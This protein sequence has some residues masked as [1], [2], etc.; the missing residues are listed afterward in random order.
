ML[1]NSFFLIIIILF[2]L[3]G[4][5]MTNPAEAN[6]VIKGTFIEA[7]YKEVQIDDK[8]TEKRLKSITIKNDQGKTMTFD[9]DE[10]PKL[11]VDTIPTIIDAFKYGMKIEV[12]VNGKKAIALRGQSGENPG[13]IE[14][15]E[16]VVTGTLNHIDPNG[17]YLSIRLENGQSQTYYINEETE[18]FK[19]TTLVDLSVLYE[20]DRVKF[21][22]NEYDSNYISTVEVN[23]Q[24]IRV[25]H[26][27][28]GTI[29]QIDSVQNKLI[30]KNEKVFQDWKWKA[31]TS[32]VHNS[33]T[34][35]T[36]TPIYVGDQPIKR[37][38]LRNYKNNEVYFV[39]I[40]KLGKEVIDKI[41]I[42]K[43]NERTFYEPMTLV[44]PSDKLLGL[45]NSGQ[46]K[47]HNGTILIRN[48]RIVDSNSLL[49]AGT[50]FV[51]TDGTEKSQFA[52]V[53]HITN[54]GF[55]SPNLANHSI[56]FGQISSTNDYQLYVN[57]TKVLVNNYWQNTS[58]IRLSFSNDTV[59][60]RDSG[61]SVLTVVPRVEM[62]EYVG[63][64]GYFYVKNNEIVGI[65]FIDSKTPLAQIVSVGRI[66]G[67]SKVVKGIPSII[68]VRN[69]SQWQQGAWEEA[70]NIS[71]MNIDQTTI[72]RD[73]KIISAQE[74]KEGDRIF[75]L[76][77]SKVKGRILFVN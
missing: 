58:Q 31:N 50:A 71:S 44:K 54:D 25:E 63:K 43:S 62:K 68:K 5:L 24:G 65:H 12:D 13:E 3:L 45:K 47:Y 48:G 64:Y 52:N 22:F 27:Y 7:T 6:S 1:K 46:M 35:S 2:L 39:T 9:M 41:I 60:V 14:E 19:G 34:Y 32:T 38:R 55:Q 73:G 70:G 29:Y 53:I 67:F 57:N 21:T 8:V 23:T 72:I 17:T 75:M 61:P 20:G 28:K 66:E 18:I 56:L 11:T 74:L 30:I 16:R 37:D 59:T 76:H 4:V 33:Y 36:K 15:G 40:N 49:A 10:N 77:E 51:I 69:V 42:K 26:L